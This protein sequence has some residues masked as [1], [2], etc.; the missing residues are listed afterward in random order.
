M[1]H[2]PQTNILKRQRKILRRDKN[3]EGDKYPV[4]RGTNKIHSQ[5]DGIEL[6][7]YMM[8]YCTKSSPTWL[9]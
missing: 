6:Y 2:A 5:T 9:K 4:F 7:I 8:Q 1:I 3:I